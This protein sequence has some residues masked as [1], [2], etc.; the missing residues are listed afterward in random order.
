MTTNHALLI[1]IRPRFVEAIFAGTK[2]VEL[3]RVKPRIIE[4]DL[5]VVYASGA[6]KGIV[7]A[8]EVGGVT[9]APPSAIWKKHRGGS[10]LERTEFNSYFEGV[11]I[12]HAIHIGKIW[13]LP[14]P[15]LLGTLRDRC[16][17][18]RP[19]Q[20]YHYWKLDDIFKMSGDV[21]AAGFRTSK[22]K[23]IVPRR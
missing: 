9:T 4:G 16:A 19:P 10:G 2:T 14:S 6:T 23:A 5:V 18:F 21:L 11:E 13:K 22:P 7:G 17:G 8:F 12:G 1:S 3:R 15:I 20:S